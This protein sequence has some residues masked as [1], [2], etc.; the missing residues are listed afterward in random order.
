MYFMSDY[1]YIYS[2]LCTCNGILHIVLYPMVFFDKSKHKM[3]SYILLHL[4]LSILLFFFFVFFFF[5]LFVLFYSYW[6]NVR[7][8]NVR[9][10]SPREGV[11]AALNRIIIMNNSN[12]LY[13]WNTPTINTDNAKDCSTNR[14]RQKSF[15]AIFSF[16]QRFNRPLA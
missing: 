7:K 3:Y 12:T 4:H 6:S 1:N 14:S 15:R 9:F 13:I 11:G 10:R 8:L 5:F 2:I 16:P